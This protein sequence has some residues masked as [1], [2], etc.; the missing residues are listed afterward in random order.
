MRRQK[1]LSS[2]LGSA[3]LS[4]RMTRRRGTTTSNVNLL[5]D[6]DVFVPVMTSPDANTQQTKFPGSRPARRLS[7]DHIT[8]S[9]YDLTIKEKEEGSANSVTFESERSPAK[10]PN[11]ATLKNDARFESD[12][13]ALSQD[14]RMLSRSMTSLFNASRNDDLPRIQL[15]NASSSDSMASASSFSV[16]S[17]HVGDSESDS[18]IFLDGDVVVVFGDRDDTALPEDILR[19]SPFSSRSLNVPSPIRRS[20]DGNINGTVGKYST[21]KLNSPSHF[22]RSGT[23]SEFSNP[24]N[25]QIDPK[26]NPYRSV[27]SSITCSKHVTPRKDYHNSVLK[28]NLEPVSG[29]NS[30]ALTVVVKS[31][32]AD[33]LT[34]D[35]HCV[36]KGDENCIPQDIP[37]KHSSNCNN[38]TPKAG[39]FGVVHHIRRKS[40]APG[41]YNQTDSESSQEK[42]RSLPRN[43]IP[44]PPE[45]PGRVNFTSS[46]FRPRKF[47]FASTSG[48]LSQKDPSLNSSLTEIEATSEKKANGVSLSVSNPF[49]KRKSG[50]VDVKRSKSLLGKSPGFRKKSPNLARKSSPYRDL[51]ASSTA[52]ESTDRGLSQLPP[53]SPTASRLSA[54]AISGLTP[55]SQVRQHKRH[56]SQ[57]GKFKPKSSSS[58]IPVQE[59]MTNH[60]YEGYYHDDSSSEDTAYTETDG[61]RV[62]RMKSFDAVV[63]DVLK[64]SP[65]EFAK[66]LTLLDF[67]VFCAI[68]PDE[69]STCGWT[70]KN[71]WKLSPH[72][73]AMTRRFNHTSFWVIREILN[74]KTLKIRAEILIHFIKI[75]KKLV[76]LNNLHSLMAVIQSLNSSSIFRLTKTWALVN[77][78]HKTT[79]DRLLSLVKED[80]NRW[81]LRSHMESIRLPCI[82]FL[83]MY[84][85]DVMYINSAHPDTGG[86]ESHE[87]TNKMNNIL[88]VISEFQQSNYDH[89]QEQPHIKN[90]LN[91][92]KYIEELQKFLEEDNYKL[93]LRIE[94]TTTSSGFQTPEKKPSRAKDDFSAGK[95]SKAENALSRHT[96]Q[97]P[98]APQK[99]VPGHR[100][101]RS[102]GREFAYTNAAPNN[103]PKSD[104]SKV[105]KRSMCGRTRQ[106]DNTVWYISP[107]RLRQNE[108]RLSGSLPRSSVPSST[109]PVTSLLDD[110]IIATPSSLASSSSTTT[111]MSVT[112]GN[113][114]SIGSS[115]S[116]SGS[117][118]SGEQDETSRHSS[119]RTSDLPIN[120]QTCTFEG[121]LK[122]KCVLKLGKKPA[123]SSW[124]KYWISICGTELVYFAAK[125]LRAQ[126]R[127]HFKTRPCKV[128]PILGW[129]LLYSNNPTRL[130]CFQLNNPESGNNYRFQCESRDVALVWINNLKQAIKG[131]PQPEQDLINL[132]DT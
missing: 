69:I 106:R 36:E 34:R 50:S 57:Q 79:F 88:R 12:L 54:D 63:F 19:S 77:K 90:Y 22:H 131:Y 80:D 43:S 23:C 5:D 44:P 18:D 64:V 65:E 28:N 1:V 59:M 92:V 125:G 98:P 111:R 11:F 32:S 26:Q 101:S 122:R 68:L 52:K 56:K 83:G 119:D 94:P 108:R 89:L 8:M 104:A 16:A 132:D 48:A 7:S 40:S 117:E 66:Q 120:C 84:L 45:S 46:G 91:S 67:P 39:G 10:S 113:S 121:C 85:S 38:A 129:L 112:G 29:C 75:A 2:R 115:R 30:P 96:S 95:P 15:F 53:K 78:H 82:P 97:T 42:S 6:D 13:S 100:K 110:S 61:N 51:E 93:S 49:P 33:S 126:E 62:P 86:L 17:C 70:K 99:F 37:V 109:T 102:L 25:S 58:W 35:R 74:A 87:R 3:L 116:N 114:G 71:K 41:A 47:R 130:D 107:S 60:N 127:H 14:S 72:V 27:T 20:S 105:Q 103:R 4:P 31:P 9:T 81:E 55:N 128:V 118:F 123:V 21:E 73:V 24:Y 124:T 76:E